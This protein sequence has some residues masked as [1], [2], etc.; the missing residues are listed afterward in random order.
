MAVRVAINGFGRIGRLVLRAIVESG[1]KDITV[2][3]VNDLAPIETNAHLLRYDFVHGRF[4]R[5]VKVDGDLMIVNGQAI[6]VTAIRSPA[7][8]AAQGIGRGHRAGMHR[9]LHLDGK[10][11]RASRS[12]R[13]ARAGFRARRRRRHH[14]RLWREPRRS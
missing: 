12:R 10:S 8:L 4:P 14:G 11:F 7:E 1:R 2:V 3:G 5:D 6:K 13:Q 9:P